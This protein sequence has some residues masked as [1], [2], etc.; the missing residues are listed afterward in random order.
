MTIGKVAGAA[1]INVETIRFYERKG[2]I[3]QPPKP[4]TGG[5]REYG[6]EILVRLRFITQAKKIG[7]SLSEIVELLAL[8]IELNA[9]CKNVKARAVAKRQDV[10]VKLEQLWC[11]RDALDELISRCPGQGGLSACTILEA[12]EQD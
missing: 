5:A 4:S 12:M 3:T 6:S 7:F 1:G 9:D 10:Q 11:M 2:L 8:R